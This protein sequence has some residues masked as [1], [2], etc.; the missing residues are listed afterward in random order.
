MNKIEAHKT[1]WRQRITLMMVMVFCCLI[2]GVEYFPQEG[3]GASVAVEA[4]SDSNGNSDS[5]TFLNVAVDAVVPF[6][7]TLSQQIFYLIY[8]NI[9]RESQVSL[10]VPSRTSFPNPFLEI[11]LERIISPNA[12]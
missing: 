11:L 12:P 9:N 3:T 4:P 10:E 2:S 5:Q 6:V 8:E 7:T 1:L